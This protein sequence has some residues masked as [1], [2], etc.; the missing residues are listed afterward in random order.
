MSLAQRGRMRIV[1]LLMVSVAVSAAVLAGCGGATADGGSTGESGT[2][3]TGPGTTTGNDSKP[4]VSDPP[5]VHPPINGKGPGLVGAACPAPTSVS[6]GPGGT[7]AR[8]TGSALRLQLVY[9]G[10]DIGVTEARG[11]DMILPPPSGP[12]E[13]GKVAGYWVEARTATGASYQHFLQ[14]PTMIEAVGE[15]GGGFTNLPVDKCAAKTILAD[16]PNDPSTTEL[17]VYGSPYG[18]NDGAVELARFTV[19]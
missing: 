1:S 8:P 2:T 12:F 14:D 4:G 10:S 6:V 3:T 5:V 7:I 13:A 18:T 16:V 19:K 17:R 11:V 15:G 9:Q